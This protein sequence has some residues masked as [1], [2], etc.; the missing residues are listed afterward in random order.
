MFLKP[1]LHVFSDSTET[2]YI[3]NANVSW[4]LAEV[5]DRLCQMQDG[6]GLAHAISFS[7]TEANLFLGAA[8]CEAEGANICPAFL[9]LPAL[10]Q[11]HQYLLGHGFLPL[12][13]A[14]SSWVIHIS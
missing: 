2:R 6:P 13:V 1:F 11:D 8:S 7:P 10:I 14:L 9:P 12:I 4:L 5:T 3:W